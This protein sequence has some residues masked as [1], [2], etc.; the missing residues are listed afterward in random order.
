VIQGRPGIFTSAVQHALTG[1]T[2]TTANPAHAGEVLTMWMT[3][4]DCVFPAPPDGVAATAL[5]P[6]ECTSTPKVLF[7]Q[8]QAI[9]LFAGLGPG[10]VGL[11]QVNIQLPQPM[12]AGVGTLVV[13]NVHGDQS[14]TVNLPI[15]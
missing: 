11:R 1:Q 2:V 4:L 15:Q 14:N 6:V 12:K 8:E 10:L 13:L 5:P 7:N 3:G 9:V